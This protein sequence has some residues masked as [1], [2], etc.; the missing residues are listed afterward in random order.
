MFSL[1]KVV[2]LGLLLKNDKIIYLFLLIS[3]EQQ[4]AREFYGRKKNK[5]NQPVI[6]N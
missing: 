5:H 3:E 4:D 2:K 6:E 1:F